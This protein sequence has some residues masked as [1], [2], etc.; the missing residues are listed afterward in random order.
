MYIVAIA[1]LYVVLMMSI[2]EQSVTAGIM[3]FTLYGL[4]PLTIILYL[5]DTPRRK[6][7]RAQQEK[8]KGKLS[9]AQPSPDSEKSSDDGN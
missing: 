5:M 3:T 6:R 9:E 7:M 8:S 2:T 1:W 4:L